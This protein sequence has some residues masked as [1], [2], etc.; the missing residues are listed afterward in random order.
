M[1]ENDLWPMWNEKT[2]LYNHCLPGLEVQDH[3]TAFQRGIKKKRTFCGCGS[4]ISEKEAEYHFH[5]SFHSQCF[6]KLNLNTAPLLNTTSRSTP[7]RDYICLLVGSCDEINWVKSRL[8]CFD[9]TGTRHC[10]REV[11]MCGESILVMLVNE[12]V[13]HVL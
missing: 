10:I 13:P 12:G 11:W 5:S 1:G 6:W 4:D 8:L 9:C 3:L 2:S 7:Q